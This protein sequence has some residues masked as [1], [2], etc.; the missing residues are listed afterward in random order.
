VIE[1]EIRAVIHNAVVV[2][3]LEPLE[4]AA[5]FDHETIHVPDW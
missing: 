5:S 2:T 3:H 1:A 4:D